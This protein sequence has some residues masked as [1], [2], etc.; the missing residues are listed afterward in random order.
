LFD[1]LF[2]WHWNFPPI[3]KRCCR[4]FIPF[5]PFLFFFLDPVSKKLPMIFLQI[6]LVGG[7]I[8]SLCFAPRFRIRRHVRLLPLKQTFPSFP[9]LEKGKP[10]VI[11]FADLVA[12]QAFPISPSLPDSSEGPFSGSGSSPVATN[13]TPNTATFT[14][15][16]PLAPPLL[17]WDFYTVSSA[18][19]FTLCLNRP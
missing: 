11:F 15:L 16:I 4:I 12:A 6:L 17:P 1:G 19:F 8:F 5:L 3:S 14:R 10:S 7:G 9:S 2:L 13:E 18:Q